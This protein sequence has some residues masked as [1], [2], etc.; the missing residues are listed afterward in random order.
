MDKIAKG[1]HPNS[2]K[3]LEKRHEPWKPGETGNPKGSSLSQRLQNA[4]DRPPQTP[5]DDA[6]VAEI[7]VFSTL[8]GAINRE[9]TPFREVWDRTEGKIV[10]TPT[11][12]QDNRVVN[13]I[14]S[15]EKAKELTE[16]VGDFGIF[17]QEKE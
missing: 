4:M 5:E 7:I 16:K 15:S 9:P 12:Y 8:Q 2:L 6:T 3:N 13:I 10:D 1:K 14:V 17:N 11:A